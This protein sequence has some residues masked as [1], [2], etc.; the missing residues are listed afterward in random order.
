MHSK[1]DIMEGLKMLNH[2]TKGKT[3]IEGQVKEF[4]NSFWPAN[5]PSRDDLEETKRHLWRIIPSTGWEMALDA[6]CGLGVCSVA[7]SDMSAKVVSLDISQQS[8]REAVKLTEIMSK[9]NVEFVHGSLM[10]IPY[11]DGT[12]DLILCWGVLMYVPS[13]ERVFSELAR[14]LRQGGTIVVAVHRKTTLTPL[15]DAIRRL[16]SRVPASAKGLIIKAMAMP[17]KVAATIHSK[18]AARDDL[19]I[20]AK[21]DDF[22]FVPFKRFFSIAEVQRL[23]EQHGLSTETLYEYTGRFKSSSSFIMRGTKHGLAYAASEQQRS[24]AR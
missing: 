7:L 1:A 8:L 15:H 12:F 11:S 17:I 21:I 22:Y 14:T 6:G 3:D 18:R 13:V 20:E 23:F 16:C 24:V 4:Y 19:S 9:N 10:D 5:L 2:S